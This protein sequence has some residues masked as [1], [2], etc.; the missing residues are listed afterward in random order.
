MSQPMKLPFN[1]QCYLCDSFYAKTQEMYFLYK[2]LCCK[3]FTPYC[4]YCEMKLRKLFGHGNI[5]KCVYCNKLTNAFDKIKINPPNLQINSNPISQSL[6]MNNLD[7]KPVINPFIQNKIPISFEKL[8]NNIEERRDILDNSCLNN[9]M[10]F[11]FNNKNNISQIKQIE[12]C[13]EKTSNSLNNSISLNINNNNNEISNFQ[14]STLNNSNNINKFFEINDHSLLRPLT[15]IR[16]KFIFND[17]FFGRK[18]DKS[19]S[20]NDDNDEYKGYNKSKDKLSPSKRNNNNKNFTSTKIIKI[21]MSKLHRP[22]IENNSLNNRGNN[23]NQI[24]K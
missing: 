7:F 8:N 9:K 2:C 3:G 6:S 13:D 20:S 1:T 11:N 24:N 12:N 14:K 21:K 19:N 18:R 17:T 4:F 16:R 5:F 15:K 10:T 23:T 22:N